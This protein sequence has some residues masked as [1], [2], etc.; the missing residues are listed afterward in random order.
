ML[1]SSV[2]SP[3]AKRGKVKQDHTPSGRIVLKC[4][5]NKRQDVDS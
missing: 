3:M 4:I 5:G 2:L 1:R